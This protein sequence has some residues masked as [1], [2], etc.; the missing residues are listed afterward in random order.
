MY[1]G[2]LCVKH[3]GQ[4]RHKFAS[5]INFL[6]HDYVIIIYTISLV[7]VIYIKIVTSALLTV[8]ISP[9]PLINTT[10]SPLQFEFNVTYSFSLCLLYYLALLGS[11]SLL[12]YVI[13][14]KLI[15]YLY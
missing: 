4:I 12:E 14:Q 3:S 11:L 1:R 6:H 2:T 7:D 10:P 13:E 15:H 5:N 9:P 8:F